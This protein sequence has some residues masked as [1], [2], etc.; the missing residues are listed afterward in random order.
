VGEKGQNEFLERRT[1]DLGTEE[2][3]RVKGMRVEMGRWW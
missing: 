1:M 2:G 3:G